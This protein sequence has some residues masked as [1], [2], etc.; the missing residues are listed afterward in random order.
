MH[1]NFRGPLRPRT[2][3][4]AG[5]CAAA[6]AVA[7]PAFG[8]EAQSGQIAEFA[9]GSASNVTSYKPDFFAQFR[10][11]TSF[12][13]VTRIPGFQFDGGSNARGFAGTAGNVLIDGE[14]PPSRSDS[15]SSVLAR[16]PSSAVERIDIVRGGAE[17]IDMQGKS[18]IANVIRKPDAGVTGAVTAGANINTRENTGANA[19]LQV[20]DQRNGR[21]L[22]GAVNLNASNG[23]SENYRQRIAPNGDVI[24]DA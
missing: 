16:I 17:G 14:R 9:A 19:G 11:N 23:S 6:L 21:L 24:L 8:Q 4:C 2:R 20:Q 7:S 10:P 13:M 15:L 12:D 22:E 1:N 18:I 5:V 3:L